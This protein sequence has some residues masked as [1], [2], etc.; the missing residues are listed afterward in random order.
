MP[1]RLFTVRRRFHA[2]AR[3]LVTLASFAFQLQPPLSLGQSP[4]TNPTALRSAREARSGPRDADPQASRPVDLEGVVTFAQLNRETCYLQDDT[5][6]IAFWGNTLPADLAAG[7]RVRLQGHLRPGRFAPFVETTNL[8]RLGRSQLPPG[9]PAQ[10]R[11][12][13]AGAEDGQRV[14]AVGVIRRSE[15]QDQTVE[16]EVFGDFGSLETLLIDLPQS[17]W[18]DPQWIGALIRVHGV[19]SSRF[20]DLGQFTAPRLLVHREEDIEL[21]SPPPE[22]PFALPHVP[23][24]KILSFEPTRNQ[25]SQICVTGIVT[26]L[27]SP[28]SFFIQSGNHG[29]RVELASLKQAPPPPGSQVE[30][31]GFPQAAQNA[32]SLQFARFR[33][34][35]QGSLPAPLKIQWKDGSAPI[36]GLLISIEGLL[37][38]RVPDGIARQ[39]HLQLDGGKDLLVRLPSPQSKPAHLDL[40]RESRLRLTGVYERL[41]ETTASGVDHALVLRGWSDVEVLHPGPWWTMERATLTASLLGLVV[42][43]GLT[44]SAT[45]R[46]RLDAQRKQLEEQ[47]AHRLSL[48]R[49]HRELTEGAPDAIYTLD[50]RGRILSANPAAAA[51]TGRTEAELRTLSIF[52]IVAPDEIERTRSRVQNRFGV[53][54]DAEP[55]EVDIVTTNGQRRTLEVASRILKLPDAPPLLE[56][57]ARDVTERRRAQEALKALLAT[58]ALAGGNE[59]FQIIVRRLAEVLRLDFAFIGVLEDQNRSTIRTLA[60]WH[61]GHPVA[62]CSYSL[63]GSPCASV[64]GNAMCVYPRGVQQLFPEDKHL[65]QLH[66]EAYVGLPLWDAE[67]K[68][69]GLLGVISVKPFEPDTAQIDMLR[70][71]AAR[72]GAEIDRLRAT[73]ALQASEERF[74]ELAE[75]TRDV[76]WVADLPT[77]QLAYLSPSFTRV[78]DHPIDLVRQNPRRLLRL[79]PREDR[80]RVLAALRK[81]LLEP[82]GRYATEYRIRRSDGTLGWILDEGVVIRN[83][84]GHPY[85]LSGVARDITTR[86]E[87]ELALAAERARF[88]ELFENSPDAIFVESL[89]GIVLDVNGAACRLHGLTPEQLTGRH[90]G[91]LVPLEHRQEVL[92]AFARLIAGEVTRVEGWSL[93][94][95]GSEVPVELHVSRLRHEGQDALLVH[96]RDITFRREAQE[97]LDGQKRILE[98]IATGRPIETILEELLRVTQAR[99]RSARCSIHWLPSPAE[100][101]LRVVSPSS[102]PGTAVLLDELGRNDGPILEALADAHLS[103]H[104]LPPDA[105]SLL[106]HRPNSGVIRTLLH[107]KNGDRTALIGPLQ[108]PDGRPLGAVTAILPEGIEP[109]G[110]HLDILRLAVS[111]GGVALQR[112]RSDTAL[113]EG[114]ERLRIANSALLSLASSDSVA[115]GDLGRALPE[116]TEAAARGLGVLRTNVWLLDQDGSMLRCMYAYGET[117]SAGTTPSSIRTSEFP[118][119][120][121]ALNRERFV[122]AAHVESDPRTRELYVSY[123]GPRGITST[124]D[125]GIRLGGQLVGILCHEHQGPPRTWTNQEE[126][127]AGS[128]AD[129][130]AQTLQASQRRLVEEALRQSEEAYRSVVSVLA[131]GVMLVNREGT[132][133]TFNESAASILG[134]S[135]DFLKDHRLDEVPWETIRADGSKLPLEDY[136]LNITFRTGQPVTDSVMGLHRPD[137]NWVWLSINTRPFDREPDGSIASVLVSFADITSRYAAERELRLNHDLLSAITQVQARFIA[138]A[139][140]SRNLGHML[141]ELAKMTRSDSGLIGEVNPTT[142]GRSGFL[143]CAA[144][145]VPTADEPVAKSP[146]TPAPGAS[147]LTDLMEEVL[148]TQNAIVRAAPV[149]ATLPTPSTPD[150]GAGAMHM[151]ALPL[152]MDDRILGVAGLSR[153]SKPYDPHAV[154]KLEPL[155]MTCASLFGAIR[156]A[157]RRLEAEAQIRE[158]NAELEKRVEERTADL[159]AMNEELAEFAYVVTHDLKA[160]LRGIHQLAEWLTQ[161]HALGLDENGLK[162]LALLRRRV[163]H[164]QRL[165]DGLL[166]CARVGRSPEPETTVSVSELLHDVIGVLAPP[167][168]VVI[169]V[170]NSLPTIHGN[171]ERLHQIFQNLLDNAVKYLDKPEGLIRIQA[172]RQAGAWEFRV[173]DNGPG[174]PARYREKVFQIFQRLD[175]RGDIPG[176]GL[177]L[178]LVRRII[179]ARGGRAWIESAEGDGTAVCFTWPD[180]ARRRTE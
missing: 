63:R 58:T 175:M 2:W 49:R 27:R 35:G 91:D 36:D 78:C 77:H 28:R 81:A 135:S 180:R 82:S 47:L 114:S 32:P 75:Q 68:P 131:E 155:L 61:D 125:A 76:L 54:G 132:F 8:A 115:K 12:L 158:L 5:A 95:D 26:A 96:A 33:I 34:V 134:C 163:L 45:L 138:D 153:R 46:R 145:D 112:H 22:N 177:G 51:L 15:H 170:P 4:A 160:P 39:F 90:I 9:R 17:R 24:E 60:I 3:V 93:R 6:G 19:C 178:T 101:K 10:I 144:M 66:A 129:L 99:W 140:P 72:T 53:G 151:L 136:P 118:A 130:V 44:W 48:E 31:I 102:G 67:G 168:Q 137:G 42:T 23:L 86:K 64:L 143:L 128:L 166:A 13:L 30:V 73:R 117:H 20:N 21:L 173:S 106:P 29:L 105:A 161:D 152:R 7:D 142:D 70:I 89:D 126:L 41:T 119:Y 147:N 43:L 84:E 108:E 174:I 50:T 1:L 139:D 85:R 40:E 97:L 65:Q 133:V 162:L 71:L 116:I 179:E 87:A 164:L 171:P 141:T 103:A 148:R 176:T 74:R 154:R 121:E 122:S 167:P 88:R 156:T 11:E 124:L 159:R 16:W 94:S 149:E 127:F 104:S 69:L 18:S 150:P 169:D 92:A 55:F 120:F 59:L 14:S 123:L 172:T 100:M 57:V 56:G 109:T 111:L 110:E 157:R 52:E 80:T 107:G 146:E 113:R 98:W 62:D 83:A 25:D 37:A 79:I 38:E 165:V